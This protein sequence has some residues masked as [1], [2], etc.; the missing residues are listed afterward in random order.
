MTYRVGQPVECIDVRGAT[1]LHRKQVYTCLA[2][3]SEFLRVD[4]CAKIDN[5]NH[6]W[7]AHRFRPIVKKKT[8]IGFAREIL[9]KASRTRERAA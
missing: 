1:C 4:C 3:E 7:F 9:R 8:D 2:V 6:M 5:P